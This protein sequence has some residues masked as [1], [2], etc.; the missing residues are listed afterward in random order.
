MAVVFISPKKK[1]RKFFGLAVAVFLMFLAGLALL[2]LLSRPKTPAPELVFNKPKVSLNLE[3]FGSEQFKNLDPFTEIKIQFAYTG[4]NKDNQVVSGVIDAGSEEEAEQ[5]L[6]DRGFIA[7]ELE[8]AQIG[9][10][11]PFIPY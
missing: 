7:V 5:I 6:R 3:I 8:S 1:Q 10:E 9:R 11:N 4:T 2:I